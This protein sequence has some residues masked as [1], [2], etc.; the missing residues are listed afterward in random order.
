MAKN[1]FSDKVQP[2][3]FP[4]DRAFAQLVLLCRHSQVHRRWSVDDLAANF[5]PAIGH[6]QYQLYCA[7]PKVVGGLTWA[8]LD[9]A[10]EAKLLA[11]GLTPPGEAWSGGDRLWFIDFLAPYGHARMIARH[12]MT[13]LMPAE[14][15]RGLRR[16]PGGH[17]YRTGTW[18]WRR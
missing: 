7:G 9:A 3:T 16:R 12:F 15:G 10:N 5:L 18:R 1:A 13:H 8:W 11:D 6:G 4:P 14:T 2:A 17:I